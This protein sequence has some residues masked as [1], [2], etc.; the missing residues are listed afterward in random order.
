MQ[1]QFI[2]CMGVD[3]A[4]ASQVA[5]ELSKLSGYALPLAA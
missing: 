1:K 5:D 2:A 3:A 4:K